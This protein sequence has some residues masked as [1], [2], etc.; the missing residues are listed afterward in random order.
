MLTSQLTVAVKPSRSSVTEWKS[1]GISSSGGGVPD[2]IGLMVPRFSLS[3][4]S[5]QPSA[6]STDR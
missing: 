1:Y 6:V 2:G 5:R 4:V 3:T